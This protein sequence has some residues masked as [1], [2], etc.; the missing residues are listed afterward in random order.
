VKIIKEEE[1]KAGEKDRTCRWKQEVEE[2]DGIR[3]KEEADVRKKKEG[4]GGGKRTKEDRNTNK[5]KCMEEKDVRLTFN[6]REG[7][8]GE[9]KKNEAGRKKRKRQNWWTKL[10][11]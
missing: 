11:E 5:G 1:R 7:G 3:T 6:V 2:E 10:E 8:E 4:R 9:R